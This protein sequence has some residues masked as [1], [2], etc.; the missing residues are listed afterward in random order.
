MHAINRKNE[1]VLLFAKLHGIDLTILRKK[2]TLLFAIKLFKYVFKES[3][4]SKY[5]QKKDKNFKIIYPKKSD[6][7]YV[8]VLEEAGFTLDYIVEDFVDNDTGEVVDIRRYFFIPLS[9]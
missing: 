2:Y 8:E 3:D 5:K 6:D 9:L 7:T 1:E 4:L